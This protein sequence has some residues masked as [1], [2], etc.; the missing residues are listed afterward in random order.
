M[1]QTF[2]TFGAGVVAGSACSC[3]DAL[4]SCRLL[5]A[6]DAERRSFKLAVH[7]HAAAVSELFQ[8]GLLLRPRPQVQLHLGCIQKETEVADF[9]DPS[10]ASACKTAG[11][12]AAT[13]IGAE[14]ELTDCDWRFGDTVMF[15]A[16]LADILGGGLRLQL[17]ARTELQVGPVQ[18]QLPHAHDLGEAVLDLRR[19]VLPACE[20]SLVAGT[21]GFG[22]SGHPEWTTPALSIPLARMDDGARLAVVTRLVLSF[23]VNADPSVLLRETGR[24]E[25]PFMERVIHC[26]D[27][28]IGGCEHQTRLLMCGSGNICDSS[29]NNADSDAPFV[30][31][32]GFDAA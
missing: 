16:G 17:L 1:L 19:Q 5:S 18:L 32:V 9:F 2:A 25:K 8:P 31:Q 26:A 24:V 20:P 23:S 28:P 12:E 4:P 15:V 10:S 13:P 14:A 3:Q 30:V 11:K 6:V 21:A 29:Y 27:A 22:G 7:V